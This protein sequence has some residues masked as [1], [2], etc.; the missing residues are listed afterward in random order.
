MMFAGDLH[1]K[2][3][4]AHVGEEYGSGL[5]R[6]FGLRDMDEDLK[7][8]DVSA[9][10]HDLSRVFSGAIYD[11]LVH[12]FEITRQVHTTLTLH[13]CHPPTLHF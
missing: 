12:I 6:D 13:H 5:G 2:S 1:D 7:I 8:S 4:L 10:S 9:E 11:I 3:F